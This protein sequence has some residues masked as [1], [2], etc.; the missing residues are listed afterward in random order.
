MEPLKEGAVFVNGNRLR[1]IHFRLT[2]NQRAILIEELVA[3][4]KLQ[5]SS[6]IEGMAS[7]LNK[8][9][10]HSSVVKFMADHQ[11]VVVGEWLTVEWWDRVPAACREGLVL[12]PGG[13]ESQTSTA[14]L[15]TGERAR[16]E[17][18]NSTTL[19]V[20]WISCELQ[21]TCEH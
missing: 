4:R 1:H 12:V 3:R 13:S 19:W 2:V 8:S 17:L 9:G 5:C 10:A 20:W 14:D 11:E 15:S 21:S 6:M 18:L 16:H 7:E